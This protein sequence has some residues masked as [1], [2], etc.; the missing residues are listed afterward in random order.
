MLLP[1]LQSLTLHELQLFLEF[2]ITPLV[3]PHSRH[4]RLVSP[5][6]ITHILAIVHVTHAAYLT[7]RH[8]AQVSLSSLYHSL[9]QIFRSVQAMDYMDCTFPPLRIC[10]L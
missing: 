6:P 5:L 8:V 4:D 2:K 10:S 7:L 3:T 1:P 9:K